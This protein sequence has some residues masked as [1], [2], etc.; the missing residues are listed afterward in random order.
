MLD[1]Y[2]NLSKCNVKRSSGSVSL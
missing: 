1:I 2:I